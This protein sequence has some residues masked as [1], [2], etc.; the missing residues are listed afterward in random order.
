MK[1]TPLALTALLA[2]GT[3]ISYAAPASE[4]WTSQC[5]KCHGADGAGKTKIGAKLKL[6]DYTDATVQ[7]AMSDEEISKAIKQG[8]TVDGKEKMKAFS[9]IPDDDVKALTAYIRTFKK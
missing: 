3:T 4:I 8:I 6:K 1:I 9:D 7:S 2:L 5:A